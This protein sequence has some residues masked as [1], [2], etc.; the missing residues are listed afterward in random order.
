MLFS[1]FYIIKGTYGT[2]AISVTSMVGGICVGVLAGLAH[3]SPMRGLRLLARTY[4]HSIRG[5]PILVL[6][7]AV[8]FGIPM[9]TGYE[10]SAFIAITIGFIVWTGAYV[11]EIVRAGIEA[12]HKDQ[13]DAARAIG[14]NYYQQLRYVILPQSLKIIIPPAASL[15][16]GLVKN[17]SLAYLLGYPELIKA[18]RTVMQTTL[19]TIPIFFTISVI[20]FL[21][22]YPLSR[23]SQK[24]EKRGMDGTYNPNY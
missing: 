12:I 16:I 23:L 4:S 8:F 1:V 17:T 18:G 2:L 5:V 7:F 13:W 3:T 24:W 15:F 20:Y 22:C 6:L 11:G 21:I 9:V 14:M 19:L 10:P